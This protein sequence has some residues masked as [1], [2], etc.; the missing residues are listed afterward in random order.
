MNHS[1]DSKLSNPK[2]NQK[3]FDLVADRYEELDGRRT[4]ELS[5]WLD[6]NLAKL[7]G[8]NKTG[9]L[10]D[11]GTG[12]G[13][14]LTRAKPYFSH[15]V[16]MDISFGMLKEAVPEHQ[17]LVQADS[18]SLPFTDESFDAVTA[19]AVLHHI[20]D[21]GQAFREIFRVLRPGGRFY[22][23]HDLCGTFSSRFSWP[24]SIYR[25]IFS[26]KRRYLS[27][28]PRL[29]SELYELT[30]LHENGID[31]LTLLEELKAVGFK[32]IHVEYHW[33]GLS[34]FF[35]RLSVLLGHREGSC[36]AGW[37]PSFALFAEK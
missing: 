17:K 14:V 25:K 12:T 19:L 6:D 30:E 2:A 28:E 35:N 34:N 3:Y 5:W 20:Q 22:S 29:T 37:A 32:N 11:L 1:T 36:P 24:L 8:E 13:F 7:A 27:A 31:T 26:I 16:G 15:L 4:E 23:D 9:S 10:L 33:R 21:H 18:S